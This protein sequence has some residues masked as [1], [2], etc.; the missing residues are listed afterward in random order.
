MSFFRHL[1]LFLNLKEK[2]DAMTVGIKWNTPVTWS[3]PFTNYDLLQ[4]PLVREADIIHLHWIAGF[5]DYPTFF[6]HLK[7]P[8]V[9]TCHDQNIALGGFHYQR[10]KDNNYVCCKPLEDMYASL[11]QKA[12]GECDSL[13]LVALSDMMYQYLEQQPFLSNIPISK[14]HNSVD[15]K[16]FRMLDKQFARNVL[17]IPDNLIIF[18][19]CAYRLNDGRKGLADLIDAIEKI[20]NK[21][22]GLLCIGGG[23]LPKE[24]GIPVFY[25]GEINSDQIMSLAYS[26]ADYFAMPSFQE[27]FAQTPLEAMACGLPVVAYPCSGTSELISE[28]NGVICKDFKTDALVK[29]IGE[30]MAKPYDRAWIRQNVIDQYSPAHIAEQYV[31][32][33]AAMC[34]FAE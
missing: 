23:Q 30:L 11:K 22:I 17:E 4:S 3:S 29:G 2:T 34:P 31:R 7:K 21:D 13:H 16:K 1:G 32:I 9:W 18:A 12:I 19:F 14:V 26:A 24:T 33:Y 27:V 15:A 25:S 20:G 28:R 10:D 6:K 8:V 5:I